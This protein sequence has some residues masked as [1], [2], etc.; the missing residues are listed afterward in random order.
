MYAGVIWSAVHTAFRR[1]LAIATVH[2]RFNVTQ[3][4]Y[5]GRKKREGL[6]CSVVMPIQ[7]Q[8]WGDRYG[9]VKDPFGFVWAIATHLEDL[10]PPEIEARRKQAFGSGQ[11]DRAAEKSS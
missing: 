7:E 2:A 4:T 8:F 10:S 1:S 5:E 6:H 9:E 11:A 3:M